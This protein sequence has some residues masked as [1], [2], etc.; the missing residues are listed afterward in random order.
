[1]PLR[2]AVSAAAAVAGMALWATAAGAQAA[3][4]PPT[5]VRDV[6]PPSSD[7]VTYVEGALVRVSVPSNWREL[8]GSNAVT[9][10]P[11]GAYLNAGIKSV[12]THG[13]G[14][15]L[16]RNDKDDLRLTTEDFIKA[17]VLPH[18]LAGQVFRHR[19]TKVG[20]RHALQTVLSSISE[21]TGDLERIEM[22]TTL[23][24]DGTVLYV[25]AVAPRDSASAY[26]ETFRRIVGS[27][28][29]MDCDGCGR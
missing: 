9:F 5:I 16:A 17:Y 2:A 13:V 3:A 29:I 14:L 19:T 24:R 23:L 25:L 10:A 4:V 26:A 22:F 15:G 27:I 20:G 11:E 28:E 18:P 12:F 7:F 21:A 1:M 8:P 6:A